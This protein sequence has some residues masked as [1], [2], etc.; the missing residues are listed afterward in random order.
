MK[1]S[2]VR[3]IALLSIL[4]ILLSGCGNT[5]TINGVE[6]DTYGLID[7]DTKKDPAIEYRII[8]GNIVW[9]A[10][11]SET[12]IAS[13]YFFGFSLFEPVGLKAVKT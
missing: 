9:G 6:Y 4:L 3:L 8:W 12:I 13:I 1:L 7:A 11:L 2:I 10:I 5:K